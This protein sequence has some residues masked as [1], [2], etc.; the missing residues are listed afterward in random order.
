MS[1]LARSL[2]LLIAAW[3]LPGC[4]ASSPTEIDG[5]VQSFAGEIAADGSMEHFFAVTNAGGV[6]V[7][8]LEVTFEPPRDE[9]V[10]TPFLALAL[11][12]PDI[13]GMCTLT[14]QSTIRTGT[15]LA[16]SLEARDYCVRV[17]DRGALGDEE[18]GRYA[19]TISPSAD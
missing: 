4:D 18:T 14:F 11:G 12:R 17:F 19:F 9:D 2:P 8:V 15:S 16:F 5:G 1:R 3:V 6:K 10:V 7:D 13:E